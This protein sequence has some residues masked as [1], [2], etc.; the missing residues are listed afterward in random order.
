MILN[1]LY[2][3]KLKFFIELNLNNVGQL[4]AR[5]IIKF[6]LLADIRKELV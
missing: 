6:Y 4:I 5:M 3:F 1:L 2:D